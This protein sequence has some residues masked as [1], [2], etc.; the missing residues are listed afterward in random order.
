MIF[1]Y[2]N[3]KVTASLDPIE[4]R[5]YIKAVRGN[6]IENLCN[7]TVRMDDYVKPIVDGTLSWRSII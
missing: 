5:R 1:E 3:L 7:M 2:G 4:G 6:H